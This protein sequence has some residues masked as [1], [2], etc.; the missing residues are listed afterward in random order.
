MTNLTSTHQQSELFSVLYRLFWLRNLAIAVQLTVIFTVHYFLGI[1]LPFEKMMGAISI[2]TV[3]NLFIVWRMKQRFPVTELEIAIHLGFDSFMLATLLYYAGG[4][5]NPFVSLF[6]VPIALAASFLSLSYV[7]AIALL[8]IGLYSFLMVNHHHMPSTHGRFGGDFN[9]H[10]IGMW[11]NFILSSIVAVIFITSLANIARE[12]A[13]KLASSEKE[14]LKNEYVVSLGTL[15]AG[16]AHEISTPLSNIGMMADE[17]NQ[18]PDDI[19]LVKEFAQS[20]KEQQQHCVRQLQRLRSTSEQA[21]LQQVPMVALQNFI[22]DILDNWAAMRPEIKLGRASNLTVNPNI[23]ADLTITQAI[24]N[25]LNNAAD[26]SLE[27]RHPE[28]NVSVEIENNN[29]LLHIDDFGKG[30]TEG[31]AEMAGDISFTTKDSGLGLGLILSHASLARYDGS[32]T[33]HQKDVGIRSS[34]SIPLTKI[35]ADE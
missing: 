35:L 12:R 21:E 3:F 5:T 30:F 18:S 20:I 19:E 27:N 33:L 1:P 26:A 17:L 22:D 13:R 34:I 16:T 32:L 15:A 2:L 10:V 11:I 8:C 24:S 28:V 25:L 29:L 6:L 4:S 14:L 23:Q 9:L 31:Q 7:I